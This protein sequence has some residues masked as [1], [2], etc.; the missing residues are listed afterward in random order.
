MLRVCFYLKVILR[1]SRFRIIATHQD[2]A[3][4]NNKLQKYNITQLQNRSYCILYIIDF[5]SP[6]NAKTSYD[7]LNW[8]TIDYLLPFQ[9]L[10]LSTSWAAL[11]FQHRTS[12]THIKKQRSSVNIL[13]TW[14]LCSVQ[15]PARWGWPLSEDSPRKPVCAN[16]LQY[17]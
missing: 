5:V 8:D 9:P 15:F 16:F 13:V 14:I 4:D 6:R 11:L 1:T 7:I 17:Y 2:K 10:D 3:E 12:S